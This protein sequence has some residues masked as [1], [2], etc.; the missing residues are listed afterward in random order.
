MDW[1][2]YGVPKTFV[3]DRSGRIVF[4]HVGPLDEKSLK[5]EIHPPG[6]RALGA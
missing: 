3:V 2:V 4:K 6:D 5:N 1:G